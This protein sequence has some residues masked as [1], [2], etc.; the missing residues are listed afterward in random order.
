MSLCCAWGEL[1]ERL[2]RCAVCRASAAPT[3]AE[4]SKNRCYHGRGD[5]PTRRLTPGN[6]ALQAGAGMRGESLL[7]R[8]RSLLSMGSSVLGRCSSRHYSR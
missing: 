7:L 4:E 5:Q 8:C 3:S 1:P 2:A 6:A